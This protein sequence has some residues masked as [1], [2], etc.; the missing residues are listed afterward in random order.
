MTTS[1]QFMLPGREDKIPMNEV[2][3]NYTVQDIRQALLPKVSEIKQNPPTT[4]SQIRLI[5]NGR[6]LIGTTPLDNIINKSIDPPYTFQILIGQLGSNPDPSEQPPIDT[7][8]QKDACCL[9]I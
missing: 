6:V 9:L 3:L 5:Y 8:E 2:S 7:S 1:L 4:S